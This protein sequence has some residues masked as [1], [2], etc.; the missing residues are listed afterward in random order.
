MK[1]NVK[2]EKVTDL[3]QITVNGVVIATTR[4]IDITESNNRKATNFYSVITEAFDD[5]RV[6]AYLGKTKKSNKCPASSFKRV[7][8]MDVY[9][10]WFPTWKEAVA[11]AH[12]AKKA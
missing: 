1:D 3:K 4:H 10:D 8:I 12:E 2:T 11:F 5:G 7:Q 9:T 6:R